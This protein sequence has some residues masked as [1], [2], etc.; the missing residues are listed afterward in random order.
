[1]KDGVNETA[2]RNEP[3]HSSSVQMVLQQKDIFLLD[4]AFSRLTGR[5]IIP[6]NA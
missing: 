5:N 3:E 4:E 1:M 6:E 2:E